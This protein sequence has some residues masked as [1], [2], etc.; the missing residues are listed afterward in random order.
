MSAS[1]PSGDAAEQVTPAPALSMEQT[2]RLSDPFSL[3]DA[4]GASDIHDISHPSPP[5]QHVASAPPKKK[6]LLPR[7]LDVVGFSTS[8]NKKDKGR[9]LWP[10][11]DSDGT[12][13][14][15]DGEEGELV[16]DEG[17]Y[18]VVD[19]PS[20]V[21]LAKIDFI[22]SLP[23]EIALHI[24]RH[25]DLPAVLA[26]LCVSPYW[27]HLASDKLVWRDLFYQQTR[28]KI[29]NLLASRPRISSRSS[30]YSPLYSR[31]TRNSLLSIQS[32][33]VP[34]PNLSLDWL[35]MY[36]TGVQLDRRWA[37]AEPKVTRLSGHADR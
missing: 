23:P 33:D 12:L 28:W 5:F 2:S 6:P 35:Q 32:K 36:K 25:L 26:C 11:M 34:M 27:N 22:A 1:L 3:I 14:P 17:C 4:P 19:R 16:E 9:L 8:S 15:L 37:S 31:W 21:P 30:S 18:D 13:L 10:T 24:L 20:F 7:I 29:N